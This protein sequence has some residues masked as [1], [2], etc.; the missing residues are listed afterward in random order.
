MDKRDDQGQLPCDYPQRSDLC[1][2]A[3][4]RPS[5][6]WIEDIEKEDYLSR[7][8]ERRNQLRQKLIRLRNAL[9]ASKGRADR[10]KNILRT[11][12]PRLD[13]QQQVMKTAASTQHQ[14]REFED[15]AKRFLEEVR[16]RVKSIG[17]DTD[18]TDE[19]L[20][21]KV[22]KKRAYM[23]GKNDDFLL[24]TLI[25]LLTESIVSFRLLQECKN[26]TRNC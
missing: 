12:E 20:R 19:E 3:L 10:I 9:D 6:C 23:Q 21:T 16:I 17:D 24:I 14:I 26:N 11:I 5:V 4:T 18:E 7:V 13:E 15:T 2:E 22:V 1:R 8:E 25:F